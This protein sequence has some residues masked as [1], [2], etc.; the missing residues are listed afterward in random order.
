MG[1]AIRRLWFLAVSFLLLS[2]AGWMSPAAMA[3]QGTATIN[4][5]VKDPTGAAIPNARVELTNVGTSVVRSTSTNSDGAYAFPSVVPGVVYHAGV[6]HRFLY[7]DATRDNP[8]SGPDRD[9]RFSTD[10]RYRAA[11]RY[12]E[13]SGG[14]GAGDCH[15]GTRY[16][17]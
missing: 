6:F 17:G 3:Q 15:L 1:G 11:E 2:L 16:S 4:G 10:G 14:G 13:R 8:G 7:G 5:V 12:R 9:L